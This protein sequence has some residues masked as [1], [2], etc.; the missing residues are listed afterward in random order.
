MA[1]ESRYEECVAISQA[2]TGWLSNLGFYLYSGSKTDYRKPNRRGS[3]ILRIWDNGITLSV[4]Q[5]TNRGRCNTEFFFAYTDPELM[6]KIVWVTNYGNL[7]LYA[8]R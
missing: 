6:D 3:M 8:K 5:Y 7:N 2:M 4:E 1:V